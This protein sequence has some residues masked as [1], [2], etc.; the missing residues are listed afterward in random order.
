ML[1]IGSFARPKGLL[2]APPQGCKVRR[3]QAK[4]LRLQI[5]HSFDDC[6]SRFTLTMTVVC[7]DL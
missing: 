2:T 3:T 6:L 1:C 5:C 4:H 7:S